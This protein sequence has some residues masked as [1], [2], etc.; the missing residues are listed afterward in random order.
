MSSLESNADASFLSDINIY[1]TKYFN[2]PASGYI[3][4]KDLVEPQGYVASPL[5]LSQWVQTT[6]LA[7]IRNPCGIPGV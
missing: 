3:S 4:E 2:F 7:H 1:C 5:K 6:V